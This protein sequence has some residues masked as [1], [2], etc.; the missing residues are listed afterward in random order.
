MACPPQLGSSPF[1]LA[2]SAMNVQAAMTVNS[3]VIK[4][5][6][7]WSPD[8]VDVPLMNGLRVQILPTIEDLPR[9]RKHQFAA[10]VASEGL[11]IVWDD[12]PLHLV[13]RAKAIESE[14]MEL[15][16]KAGN[17]DDEEDEKRGGNIAEAEIDEESGEVKPE[18]RPIHLQ[19]TVL[20]SL[21]LILVTV[22]LGAAWRE[23]AIEVSVDGN[24]VVWRSW[25][26]SP[27]KSSLL[28]SSP[29]SLSAAWLRSSA[30]FGSSPSTP[31][32]TRQ[33]LRLACRPPSCLTSPSSVLFTRKVC[34]A[35]LS[36]PSSPS[37][38]PCRPM[39]FRAGQP[40]C[41]SMMTVCSSSQRRSVMPASNF[42]P[43]TAL[44]GLRVPSMERTASSVRAS[45]RR[46]P[47]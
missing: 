34:K 28:S 27:S 29:K 13:Q 36:P 30:P 42:M 45:S 17:T 16:W 14:L 40:T 11:L 6:L 24:Y 41:L 2:C 22:S 32:S 18:K 21:T 10:F 37:S 47:T 39:N 20:V 3:R 9:A 5:F 8:A 33:D 43:T 15:V 26:C 44:A 19:N 12:D 46:P 35:S 1:A 7:Q 38:K 25:P 4:T 31:S 23:L